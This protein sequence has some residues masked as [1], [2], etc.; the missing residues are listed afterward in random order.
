M[1]IIVFVK[2]ICPSGRIL[3]HLT[4]LSPLQPDTLSVVQRCSWLERGI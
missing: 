2:E 3:I 4:P 1:K